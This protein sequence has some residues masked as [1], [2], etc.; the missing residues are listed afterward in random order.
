MT[1]EIIARGCAWMTYKWLFFHLHAIGGLA[2]AAAVSVSA[3]A[4]VCLCVCCVFYS[5]ICVCV[6]VAG[7]MEIIRT[8]A[9][10]FVFVNILCTMSFDTNHTQHVNGKNDDDLIAMAGELVLRSTRTQIVHHGG[11]V[12]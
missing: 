12:C 9:P 2:A 8:C 1:A 5:H 7:V 10:L 6:C 3:R 4:Y 11:D